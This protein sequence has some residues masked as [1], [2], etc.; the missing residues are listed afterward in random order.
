MLIYAW[1]VEKD[2]FVSYDCRQWYPLSL[3]S[4]IAFLETPPYRQFKDLL[5][6]VDGNEKY[7]IG[8]TN[9][10]SNESGVR[11][12]VNLLIENKIMEI[13]DRGVSLFDLSKVQTPNEDFSLFLISEKGLAQARSKWIPTFDQHSGWRF[14]AVLDTR[15]RNSRLRNYLLICSREGCQVRKNERGERFQLLRNLP[16]LRKEY[17]KQGFFAPY[18]VKRFQDSCNY[19]KQMAILEKFYKIK[20]IFE[21]DCR[22]SME[23]FN[24]I[25]VK[26]YCS[27][28]EESL[29]PEIN[30]LR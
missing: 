3:I 9:Q 27:F 11:A 2:G 21:H 15:A 4:K 18:S 26:D 20:G 7:T 13:S 23:V 28:V 29:M 16:E 24:D 17:A 22:V 14:F 12:E 10:S 5:M 30:S 25:E 6:F 19:F 1:K 8:Y